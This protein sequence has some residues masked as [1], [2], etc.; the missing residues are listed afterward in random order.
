MML[1]DS[2]GVKVNN[3]NV[4]NVMYENFGRKALVWGHYVGS[5]SLADAPSNKT[6]TLISFLIGCSKD[7]VYSDIYR[8]VIQ[9]VNSLLESVDANSLLSVLE[10]WFI[11]ISLE[12]DNSTEA[13]KH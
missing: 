5:D 13:L 12:G 8:V 3:L 1:S 11:I 9:R 4:R 7:S 6:F 10:R 2:L